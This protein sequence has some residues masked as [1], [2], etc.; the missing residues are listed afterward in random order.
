MSR[1]EYFCDK[2]V[3]KRRKVITIKTQEEKESQESCYFW[4]EVGAMNESG[5]MRF[6]GGGVILTHSA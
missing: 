2:I 4:R 3:K 1:E 6:L 5:H